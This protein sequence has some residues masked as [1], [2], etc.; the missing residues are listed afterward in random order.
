MTT[1]DTRSGLGRRGAMAID[2]RVDT[3]RLR[4][5]EMGPSSGLTRDRRRP[6]RAMLL[7]PRGVHVPPPAPLGQWDGPDRSPLRQ[8]GHC[9]G[10]CVIT[11]GGGLAL[12]LE[13]L[14]REQEHPAVHSGL[15]EFLPERIDLMAPAEQ[16]PCSLGPR[17][18]VGE[19]VDQARRRGHPQQLPECPLAE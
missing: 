15:G 13:D 1:T 7:V 12:A 5:R 19:R 10:K 18:G 16:Y 8:P 6:A 14:G 2:T 17:V 11:L 9:P 3:G 4:W